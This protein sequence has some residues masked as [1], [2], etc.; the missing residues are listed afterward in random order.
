VKQ[1]DREREHFFGAAKV[2]AGITVLSR[3]LGL[4]RDM[5]IVPLGGAVLA[6]R[7]WTAFA[8]PNLFRRLFG[9]GALSAAFV[10]VFTQVAEAQGWDRAR[11]VLANV[12]GL[13]AAVL[14]GLL[15]LTELGL[16]AAWTLWPGG[17]ARQVLL[18]LTATMMPFM[19]TVC[20]LALGSAALNCK[21]HFAY[22]AFAP[23]ILNVVLI[24]AAW[25]AGKFIAHEAGQ[26]LAIAAS[27]V[28]AGAGQLA[29]VLW[30]LR[31]TGLAAMPSC[32]PVLPEVRRIASLMAPTL[33]PLSMLQLSAL[34]DR[35][36]ALALTATPEHPALPLTDGVVRCLYAAGRLYQ[37]PMGV[38]AISIATVVFPLLGRHAARGDLPALRRTANQAL[39]WG[40]FLGIPAGVALIVLAQ[41]V[42]ELIFQRNKFTAFDTA[43][44]VL[45]LRMYCLGMWAYFWNHVLLRAFFSQQD[46]RTPLVLFSVL[47]VCNAALVIGGLF[48]PLKAGAI[49]LATAVTQ[50]LAAVA[51]T[52]VLRRRWGRLGLGRIAAS[53]VRAAV[54]S[55]CM[56]GALMLAL[57]FLPAPLAGLGKPAG[58]IILLA[59]AVVVGT[60]VFAVAALAL[61]CPELPELYGAARRKS[62]GGTNGAI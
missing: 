8:V 1:A 60:A 51:L 39:R 16:L 49:G 21:G 48:T 11:V 55:A 62:Q 13:L 12:A 57:A 18:A 30:L 4:V 17:A 14:A 59:A 50:S 15:V 56:A 25:L 32:R 29:G 37:L 58:D 52:G 41:P 23:I 54:A 44:A 40:V 31:R 9:E 24:A 10:P 7:F 61:R 27:L 6:D 47:A 33:L 5:L 19:F 28:L 34:A 42:I 20:L 22:P 46:T 43:R 45:I 53:A 35:L 2:V 3:V 36:I 38:L 26:F